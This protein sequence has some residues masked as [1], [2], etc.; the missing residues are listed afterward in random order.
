[1]SA[2]A[3]TVLVTL[4]ASL[5]GEIILFALLECNEYAKTGIAFYE[6]LTI[7]IGA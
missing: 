2:V 1:M 7:F 6:R 5:S 3:L 4:L